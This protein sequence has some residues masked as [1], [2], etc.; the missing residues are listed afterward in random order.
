MTK[1]VTHLFLAALVSTLGACNDSSPVANNAVAPPDN[2][3]GDAPASGLAAPANSGVAEAVA[4]ASMPLPT[5]GMHWHWNEA[6]G[7]ADY[8]GG[9]GAITFSIA[10][11]GG[12]LLFHRADAAPEGGKGTISFTGNA[13]AASVPAL[14]VGDTA[15]MTSSWLASEAPSDMTSAVARVF[16][17][18]GPVEIALT[19]TMRLV[20]KPS[21]IP[22]KPFARCRT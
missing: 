9:P 13:R 21:P 19:G 10:C 16:S 20:T 18:P 22:L 7:S 12:K 11:R 1:I 3:V 15:A 5:D 14:A 2:A 4:K 8:G 17:G 6:S